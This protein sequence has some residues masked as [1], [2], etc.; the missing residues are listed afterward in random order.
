MNPPDVNHF[1]FDGEHYDANVNLNDIPFWVH[2]AKK[3]GD[4]LLELA[5]GTGRIAIPIAKAGYRVTGIDMSDSMLE[6]AR[7]KVEKE[8]VSVEFIKADIRNFHIGA[9]FPLILIP[10]NTI[11]HFTDHRDL[12]ACLSCV[13]KHLEPN[14][15]L[16]VDTHNPN[17]KYLHSDP[18]NP[19]S[20]REYISPNN[21]GTVTVTST[22][23]YDSASQV[24]RITMKYKLPDKDNEIVDKLSL[25]IYFPQ[26]LDALMSYNGFIIEDKFGNYDHDV[27]ESAS[28]KQ[29]L[30]LRQK[31]GS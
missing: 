3:F 2:Q 12:E 20:V 27:F 28:P 10:A 17:F 18:N 1:Y 13:K 30:V 15:K 11:V 29:I 9:K 22:Q 25:R 6:Q 14:G 7:R 16:I 26:E 4:P 23:H 31:S 24:N 21:K 5:V 8:N 19:P